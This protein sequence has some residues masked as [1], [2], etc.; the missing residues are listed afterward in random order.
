MKNEAMTVE[1][2]LTD[3]KNGESGV[4]ISA[5]TSQCSR[6]GDGRRR[7]RRWGCRRRLEDLGL[8]PGTKVKVIKSAPFN[9]PIEVQ[10]RSSRLALGRRMA[11]SVLVE[12]ER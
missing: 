6:R 5:G 2:R 11:E 4:I 8:T 9:G 12:V 7:R 3:M 10:V 1:L